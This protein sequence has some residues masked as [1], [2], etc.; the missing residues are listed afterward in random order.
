M[1]LFDQLKFRSTGTPLTDTSVVKSREDVLQLK[2]TTSGAIRLSAQEVEPKA[3]SATSGNIVVDDIDLG[4]SDGIQLRFAKLL[5]KLSRASKMQADEYMKQV[6]GIQGKQKE[7]AAMIEE[8]RKQMNACGDDKS[9]TTPMYNDLKAYFAKENLKMGTAK[10]SSDPDSYTKEQWE[11]NLKSLTNHQEQ[12]GTKTQS[13][14]VFL[15]DFVGQYNANLTGAK[16]A[17]TDFNDTL[18]AL[19]R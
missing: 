2:K 1:S 13:L 4:P 3:S 5:L 17:I 15:Q 9:K 14:M 8:A 7:A 6:E 10:S 11:F 16:T 19:M 18:K 12:L